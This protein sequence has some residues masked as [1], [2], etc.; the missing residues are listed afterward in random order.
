MSVGMG[1]AFLNRNSL[2]YNTNFIKPDIES[3]NMISLSKEILKRN[4]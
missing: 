2:Y 1:G 3:D 4:E